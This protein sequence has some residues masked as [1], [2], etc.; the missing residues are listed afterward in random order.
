M[1]AHIEGR[2]WFQKSYGNTYHSVTI[3]IDGGKVLQSGKRYGYGEGYLQTAWQLL[4][5]AGVIHQS[6]QYGGTRALRE[7]YGITYSV[8]DVPR[9][10]DL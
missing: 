7:T 4:Q 6:A 10:K 8:V 3:H 2:R 1:Q 5:D 9:E